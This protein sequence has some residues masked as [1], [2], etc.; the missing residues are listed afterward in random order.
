MTQPSL[1]LPKVRA[2]SDHYVGSDVSWRHIQ[3]VFGL[4]LVLVIALIASPHSPRGG[5][6]FARLRIQP[7]IVTL[8][9]MIGVRGLARWLTSN[10]NIDIGFGMDLASIF[11]RF[12]STKTM[13]IGSY[14]LLSIGLAA[15]LTNTVFGRYVRAV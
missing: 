13:V 2:S 9:T 8:A 6:I 12:F 10:T 11:S 15:L 14:V 1:G 5:L 7:F 4:L 3:S